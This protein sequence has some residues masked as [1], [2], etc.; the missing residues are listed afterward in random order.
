LFGVGIMK[1]IFLLGAYGQDNL[2][3][4]ALLEVFL[5]QF[6]GER[7]IVNSAQ[8]A[9]TRQRYGVE[10]VATYMGVPRLRRLSAMMS[11]D[12][13]V[14]G[15]GSLLKEIEGGFLARVLYLLR[16]LILLI[17][18]KLLGRPSAML[19]VGMGPIEQPLFRW[20]SRLAANLVDLI[21]VR[22]TASRDLLIS[23]GVQR[24]IHVTAD[25]VMLLQG[26]P[27]ADAAPSR[28]R[29]MVV[30][31]PRYSLTDAELTSFAA[32]CDHMVDTYNATITFMPFQ[33][34]YHARYDDLAA[35]NRVIEQMRSRAAATVVLPETAASALAVIGSADLVLSMRLHGLIFAALQGVPMV[36]IDYEVKVGNFM[37]EIDLPRA[38]VTLTDLVAG[39][40]PA[41]LDQA[42]A[43]R[44]ATTAHLRGQLERLRAQSKATIDHAR[45]LLDRGS[46][47]SALSGGALLFASMTIVNIGNYALNLVLGRWLG[48]AAFA[49]FNLMVTTFLIVTMVTA[50]FQLVSAKFAAMYAADGDHARLVL[51]RSW[52]AR[53]AWIIGVVVAAI[54]GL[55]APTWQV[56]FQ[57]SS[58]WP[59]VI[60]GIGLPFYIAQ[61]IDRG[62][63]QGRTQFGGLTLSYQAEM[64]VRL[65]GSLLLVALGWSVNGAVAA[66]TLSLVV[67]WLVGS[68][69]VRR[70]NRS[71]GVQSNTAGA[72]LLPAD[73]RAILEFCGLA[74]IALTGQ[75]LI[76]NSDVL[77]VK[78]F[79]APEEAGQYAA[80][81]LIGRVVFFITASVVATIFPIVTQAHQR[82]EAT[83]RFLWGAIGI[84]TAVSAAIVAGALV[85]PTL[86]VQLLFGESYL[87]IAPLLWA[88][89]GA[90]SLYAL[91]NVVVN[92][93]LAKGD[94]GG[95]ILV[96]LVGIAQV[97]GLWLF[98][99]SLWEVVF[100]QV[101]LMLALFAILL[102]WDRLLARRGAGTPTPP[103]AD[104]QPAHKA[105]ASAPRTLGSRIRQRLSSLLL[106]SVVLVLLLLMWQ[107]AAAA[108]SQAG[109]SPQEQVKQIIPALRDS[110]ADQAGGAYIPGVGVVFTLDLLRG[111]NT[112]KDKAPAPGVHDWAVYLMGAFG[113]RLDAVPPD[114]I[115]A[116]SINYYDFD[117]RNYHQQVIRCRAADIK[118]SSKYQVWLD[119]IPYEQ[120]IGAVGQPVQ[121]AAPLA[122]LSAAALTIDFEDG[123][124]GADAWA[125]ASGQWTFV[126][127]GYAQVELGRYDLVS[128]LK[129]PVQAPY[130]LQVDLTYVEGDMGGGII[131][132][133][134]DPASKNSAHMVSFSEKGAY[135]QWGSYDADGVFQFKG[136]APVPSSADQAPHTL[137]VD[138]LDTTY[139][140]SLDGTTLVT[141]VPLGAPGGGHVGLLAST[142]HV[143]FD[144]VKLESR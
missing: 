24:P 2:G 121:V 69:M 135:L 62:A 125:V 95:S 13:V 66:M 67:T 127:Q 9:K 51:V 16:I 8:P 131:F 25:P 110:E 130:T 91:A 5:D 93:R 14:F 143:V 20:M 81:S 101:A 42:W 106:G 10:T 140:V 99:T 45:E 47:S 44:R 129:Q 100:V 112:F 35:I 132:N 72:A 63:L 115:I 107:V 21:C 134:P 31:V 30:V 34:G 46:R 38:S 15:G 144:A 82:G 32:A 17:V 74:L 142:S 85:A 102:G 27:A 126:D 64:W 55:G 92:Y 136:G 133:A 65:I 43:Q 11:S 1:Q 139:S 138:V 79:F 56:F 36:A 141:D 39:Q 98:H 86:V 48:P 53:G 78:H 37:R 97:A 70:A 103:A 41:A 76:N 49:D 58:P 50:A 52:L 109:V 28:D 68:A 18:A 117:E 23:I 84:V 26:L 120:A 96:L 122:P 90:T 87:S 60:L 88:Y 7:I 61:G 114:E 105:V 57:T 3:D 71:L 73:K 116:I 108:P 113:P 22:D 137:R 40:M 77:I 94:R 75:V 29:P 128:M 4:D 19:G 33:T 119:G 12:M 6:R 83:E 59:F 124:A 89:A 80:L 104:P 111:P 118:D 123:E 54:V